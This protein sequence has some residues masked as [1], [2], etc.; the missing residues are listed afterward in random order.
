MTRPIPEPNKYSERPRSAPI[1]AVVPILLVLITF[2]FWYQTWFGR[3]LAD[4]DLGRYLAGTSVPHK[5]QHALAQLAERIARGDTT[6]RRWYP[7]ILKLAQSPE[8][9]FRLMAA[10]VMGQDN[11]SQ[12]F[13]QA[14]RK[15]LEDREPMVRRNAA[16]ALARFDDAAGESQLRQML[17]PYTLVAPKAGMINFR[18]KEQDAA[19]N[20]SVVARI[21]ASAGTQPVEVRSPVA[22]RIE[23]L[24]TRD[25]TQVAAGDKIAALAPDEKDVWES[26][27]ALYLVGN[28]DDLEDVER[29]TRAAPGTS[30]RVRQQAILTRDAIRRR[31]ATA[32]TSGK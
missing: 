12:E 31:A 30:E 32:V 7:E 17:R 10:W 8:A 29:F 28:W 20:G 24:I 22:G 21:R 23:R 27:R 26:L 2:L 4:R 3:R 6:V 13:H 1:I 14:L 15:L 16:L 11:T 25:G 5:T 9:Q 19:K 18:M